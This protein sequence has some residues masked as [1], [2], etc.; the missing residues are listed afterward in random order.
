MGL[1]IREDVNLVDRAFLQ[2]LILLELV[3]RDDLDGVLLL[4]VVVDCPV[5]LAVDARADRFIQDVVLDVLYHSDCY[6]EWKHNAW[7]QKRKMVRT[8]RDI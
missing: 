7:Y 2:L 6:Y 1:N 5:D 4:I 8:D 3:D